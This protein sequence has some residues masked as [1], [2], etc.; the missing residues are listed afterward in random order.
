MAGSRSY[1]T[2]VGKLGLLCTHKAT[3]TFHHQGG[4]TTDAGRLQE[5][6]KLSKFHHDH[7]KS[8]YTSNEARKEVLI[9]LP[10]RQHEPSEVRGSS[11]PVAESK[12]EGEVGARQCRS[13]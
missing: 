13:F 3:S 2:T 11:M 12:M 4:D 7:E 1:S 10:R 6:G 5:H 9:T 8:A